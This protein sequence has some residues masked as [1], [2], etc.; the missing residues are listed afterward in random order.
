MT[1]N[2][3]K[4]KFF[5]E[6]V[7]M[8]FDK[9]S[10]SFPFRYLHG[11]QTSKQPQVVFYECKSECNLLGFLSGGIGY[12]L[13]EAWTQLYMAQV[14]PFWSFSKE[15]FIPTE[16]WKCHT[17]LDTPDF[18]VSII[19]L[20]WLRESSQPYNQEIAQTILCNFF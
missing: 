19:L 14:S 2:L 18:K 17:A 20:D 12:W 15:K 7:E 16:D 4:K 5:K 6:I 9:F 10:I 8:L 1:N 3:R 11:N 13:L